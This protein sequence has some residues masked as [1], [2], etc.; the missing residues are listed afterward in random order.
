MAAEDDFSA[1]DSL[2][3]VE[4]NPPLPCGIRDCGR[5][6]RFACIERDPRYVA[7][8][9]LLPI[10]ELH[11]ARLAAAADDVVAAADASARANVSAK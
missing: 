9:R 6:A 5:P 3:R 8:W 7:L 11:Q 1:N 4:V 10:C 2:L